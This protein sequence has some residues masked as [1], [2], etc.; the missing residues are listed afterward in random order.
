MLQD[1][2]RKNFTRIQNQ[3]YKSPNFHTMWEKKFYE[4]I[5]INH[6]LSIYPM[7]AIDYL[8]YSWEL[9]HL[10][11]EEM[12]WRKSFAEHMLEKLPK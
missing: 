8:G 4:I 9:V 11:C 12:D 6:Y 3:I 7:L 5:V 2:I 10:S 1:L